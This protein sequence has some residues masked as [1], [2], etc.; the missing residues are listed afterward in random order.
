MDSHH[1]M[2]IKIAVERVMGGMTEIPRYLS[3]LG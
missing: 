2:R 1:E 3:E